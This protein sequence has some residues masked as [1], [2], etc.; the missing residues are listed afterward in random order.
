M[1]SCLSLK[2]ICSMI[3]L[4]LISNVNACISSGGRHTDVRPKSSDATHR[5]TSQRQD[6]ATACEETLQS[7]QKMCAIIAS[8]Q[9]ILDKLD[10]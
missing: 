5:G 3:V 1:D 9:A 4:L 7:V 8:N 6:I 2:L 10:E